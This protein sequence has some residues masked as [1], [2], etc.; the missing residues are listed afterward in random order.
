MNNR[1]E[2]I[3]R[4]ANNKSLEFIVSR[5]KLKKYRGAHIFQHNRYDDKQ[6]YRI[7]EIIKKYMIMNGKSYIEI[8]PGD[9]NNGKNNGFFLCDYPDFS[10]II[11][12]L[13]NEN[14]C[15]SANRL[16][17]N[18]FPDFDRSSTIIRFDKKKKFKLSDYIMKH[19]RKIWE[20]HEYFK[21]HI[22]KLLPINFIHNIYLFIDEFN[23]IDFNEFLL[24]Y[25]FIDNV[26][27]IDK[28]IE[29]KFEYVKN[30][31][32]EWR[33]LTETQKNNVLE[34]LKE[35]MNPKLYLKVTKN[36]K[37]DFH[38]LKNETK[39]I[40]ELLQ[41]SKIFRIIQNN[42]GLQEINLARDING[43][44]E[45]K[46]YKRCS[47][48]YKEYLQENGLPNKVYGYEF[49]HIIK[50]SLISKKED[51]PYIDNYKNLIYID[52]K[53]H[54]VKTQQKNVHMII[55]KD[56]NYKDIINMKDIYS[57]KKDIKLKI[58]DNILISEKNIEELIKYNKFLIEKF[59][60]S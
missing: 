55:E 21:A 1:I 33:K 37:K 2:D 14:L 7:L 53:S 25:N 36:N 60:S 26:K 22:E 45:N 12:Q 32:C 6:M 38:N 59:F 43:N 28:N 42:K 52:G 9:E 56:D 29:N 40:F 34:I 24:F 27:L 44:T 47:E 4:I 20:T 35:Y 30:L 11:N 23:Y 31:L 50:F 17:K 15:N 58:K 19:D 51:V 8:P 49:D 41:K 48:I 54:S 46:K 13:K 10:N 18:F 3:L 5:F 39:Q 57:V 16:K